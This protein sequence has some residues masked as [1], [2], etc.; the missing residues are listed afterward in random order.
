MYNCLYSIPTLTGEQLHLGITHKRHVCQYMLI[1]K[2]II[3]SAWPIISIILSVRSCYTLYISIKFCLKVGVNIIN[4][5]RGISACN[6]SIKDVLEA[7][8]SKD[9]PTQHQFLSPWK[10]D[11][12]HVQT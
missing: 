12:L 3:L 9:L 5:V 1:H 7:R 6:N 2:K 4:I 10:P 11:T 8:A